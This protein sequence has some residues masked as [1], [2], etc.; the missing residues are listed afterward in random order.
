M[1]R[2]YYIGLDI[3][4]KIIAYCVKAI[5]GSLIDQGKIGAGRQDLEAWVK[6][7]PGPWVG[8][9][10]ATIFTGWIYDFL[11]PHAVALKVAHP[12][13]LKAITAAKKKNDKADAETIA[14]LLRVN[15]LPE[16]QM[17]SEKI[18]ELRRILRYRNH[19]V[20]TADKPARQTA[21]RP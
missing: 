4:K 10:E 21:D 6:D 19:L 2:Y 20:R 1:E 16:C 7:L 18:R 14:D 17:L 3:H 15:L 9:M 5:D 8:A 11:K 13:M 12:A